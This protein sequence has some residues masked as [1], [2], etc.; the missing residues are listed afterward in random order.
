MARSTPPDVSR[1]APT[2]RL[3]KPIY[4]TENGLPDADD[5]QRPRFLLTHLAQVHRAIAE[6]V[7]VRGYYH[8]SFTDNFEWAGGGTCVSACSPW[9]KKPGT[10]AAPQRRSSTQIIGANA[11]TPEMVS[12]LRP[13]VASGPLPPCLMC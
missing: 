12:S 13:R 11:I 8:W 4:V 5:D 9:I 6:G 2:E 7:D 1:A 10:H 3:G